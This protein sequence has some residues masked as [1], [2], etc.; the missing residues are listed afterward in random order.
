[1]PGTADRTHFADGTPVIEGQVLRPFLNK[2][3]IASMYSENTDLLKAS[4]VPTTGYICKSG[5]EKID[6][7]GLGGDAKKTVVTRLSF[8]IH[9]CE[10][11]DVL[12][13]FNTATAMV[14]VDGV[15]T[16]HTFRPDRVDAVTDE[17]GPPDPKRPNNG[18]VNT[19]KVFNIFSTAGLDQG[20]SV[21]HEGKCQR[22]LMV[23]YRTIAKEK[24]DEVNFF[25][26]DPE[27][28]ISPL[29]ITFMF[30]CDTLMTMYDIDDPLF[31]PPPPV[32]SY[33]EDQIDQCSQFTRDVIQCMR[34]GHFHRL[35]TYREYLLR[36][37][38]F[39]HFLAL[40][41]D[42]LKCFIKAP[43]VSNDCRTFLHADPD[44]SSEG[45]GQAL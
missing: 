9:P 44:L 21:N 36:E 23:V 41:K 17:S 12:K 39:H 2:Q 31:H 4:R 34:N 27:H 33:T 28:H 6:V 35:T 30:A 15:G 10:E 18:Q 16:V 32:P 38:G 5:Q 13:H 37:T 1:M 22:L 19:E 11:V 25:F 3:S 42:K 43:K 40:R 26:H 45:W 29:S 14:A 7:D 24:A 20:L 8:H